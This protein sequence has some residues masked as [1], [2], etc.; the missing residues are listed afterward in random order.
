[1]KIY[2]ITFSPTGGTKKVA[3][4]LATELSDE[5]IHIDLTN[6]DEDFDKYSLTND[7]TEAANRAPTSAKSFSVLITG[8]AKDILIV[9]RFSHSLLSL[10]NTCAI[11]ASVQGFM[12]LSR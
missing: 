8:F 2:E 11:R 1:M 4:K 10:P 7:D 12:H 3:D 9:C 5:I 6:R